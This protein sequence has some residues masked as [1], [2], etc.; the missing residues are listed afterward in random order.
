MLV[1]ALGADLQPDHTEGLIGHGYEFYSPEGAEHLADVLSDFRGGK[2][3]IG[4]LGGH[5]KCPP[6]PYE[7]AFMLHDYLS[8]RGRREATTIHLITPMP[9][10]IPVSNTVSNALLDGLAERGITHSHG[11]WV[12]RL[13][14]G[15][16]HLRDGGQFDFDLFLAV[17]RH[18]APQV[19]IDSGL[20]EDDGWIAVDPATLETKWPGVFAVGDVASVPVPRAGVIAEGE[21]STVADVLLH[22]L[23]GAPLSPRPT[24]ERS[25]ATSRWAPDSSGRWTSTSSPDPARDR[26]SCRR[27]RPGPQEKEAFA[28][29]RRLRWFGL[30]DGA[31]GVVTGRSPAAGGLRGIPGKRATRWRVIACLATDARNEEP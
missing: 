24:R 2:V 15:I 14:A 16:V 10:P 21:A 23:A 11:S 13:D 9:K 31:V 8:E 20:T 5:F 6:A 26:A 12:E 4:V 22:R 18:V 28:A 17:P 30:G 1:I 25:R 3:V 27:P 7:C 29:Q 19:V